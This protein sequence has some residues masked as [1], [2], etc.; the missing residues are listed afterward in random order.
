MRSFMRF[1]CAA[2]GAERGSVLQARRRLLRAVA[3]L[4]RIPFHYI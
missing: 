3:E 1:S 2:S 4:S